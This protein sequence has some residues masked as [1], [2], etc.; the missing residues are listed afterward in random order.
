M[1]TQDFDAW[2]TLN[3]LM[4]TF[5]AS[6][7]ATD[8]IGDDDLGYFVSVKGMEPEALTLWVLSHTDDSQNLAQL[9]AAA[10]AAL[11]LRDYQDDTPAGAEDVSRLHRLQSA[12]KLI[13]EVAELVPHG[14]A[15]GIASRLRLALDDKYDTP[16]QGGAPE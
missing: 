5:R 15:G 12:V 13:A 9:A 1:T 16:T 3:S 2:A 14:A 10:I 8:P 4:Q 7:T 11:V 6:V